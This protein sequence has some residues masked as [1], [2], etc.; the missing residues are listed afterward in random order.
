MNFG[1]CSR[2]LIYRDSFP[3]T[4]IDLVDHGQVLV[5]ASPRR[6]PTARTRAARAPAHQAAALANGSL[7]FS[8]LLVQVT[9]YR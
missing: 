7:R 5:H 2:K 9:V 6:C 4:S 3:S 8:C 1:P